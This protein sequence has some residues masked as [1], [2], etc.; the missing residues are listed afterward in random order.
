MKF[1]LLQFSS[2]IC[3]LLYFWH[4]QS[5]RH[6]ILEHAQSQRFRH[7][8]TQIKNNRQYCSF[9]YFNIGLFLIAN[10]KKIYILKRLVTDIIRVSAVLNLYMHKI[11]AF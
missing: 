6:H 5:P 7:I 9:V 1:F 11:L 10:R 4:K 8:L 2:A 3:Y